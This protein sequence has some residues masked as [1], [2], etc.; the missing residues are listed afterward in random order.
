MIRAQN[1]HEQDISRRKLDRD[2]GY[3]KPFRKKEPFCERGKLL[4]GGNGP[5]QSEEG[6]RRG[7]MHLGDETKGTRK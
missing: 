7:R 6:V 2:R 4:K 3:Q 1:A 5:Q